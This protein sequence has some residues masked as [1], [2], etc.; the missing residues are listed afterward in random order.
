MKNYNKLM[1]KGGF[2]ASWQSEYI[3]NFK[4]NGKISYQMKNYHKL[5]CKWNLMPLPGKVNTH[6]NFKLNGKISYQMKNYPVKSCVNLN[7]I[8]L[9]GWLICLMEGCDIAII[10]NLQCIKKTRESRWLLT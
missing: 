8:P 5:M 7:L 4:L 1:C 10:N 9:L 3:Q 6:K 2:D